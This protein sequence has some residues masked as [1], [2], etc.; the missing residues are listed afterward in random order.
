MEKDDTV[1]VYGQASPAMTIIKI[2]EVD[3]FLFIV[4][5]LM[6]PIRKM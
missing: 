3:A 1:G 2:Q 5:I 6:N 4:L